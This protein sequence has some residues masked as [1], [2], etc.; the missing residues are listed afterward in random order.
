L[1]SLESL[2]GPAIDSERLLGE[3]ILEEADP[4]ATEEECGSDPAREPKDVD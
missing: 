3:I 4:D 2:E 1:S